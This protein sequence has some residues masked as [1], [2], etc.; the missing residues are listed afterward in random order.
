MRGFLSS[1]RHGPHTKFLTGPPGNAE[2]QRD[3]IVSNVKLAEV[4]TAQSQQDRAAE[5]YRV[6]L[7][8]AQ[9]LTEGGRLTP[10]DAGMVDDLERR[11]AATG[12]R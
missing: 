1:H 8:I 5:C 6:A 12:A 9:M 10:C 11:L 3:L 2:W 4:A 7:A